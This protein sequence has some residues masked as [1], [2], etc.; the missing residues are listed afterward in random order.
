MRQTRTGSRR[1]A[2]K[3]LVA[4]FATAAVLA[5]CGGD[6]G[7]DV[8]TDDG[9]EPAGGSNDEASGSAPAAGDGEPD[10]AAFPVTIEHALGETVIEEL[11]ETI[12]TVGFTD[13]DTVLALGVQPAGVR[14]WYGDDP[15]FPWAQELVDGEQP[16]VIGDGN[17]INLEAVAQLEP[18]LIIGIYEDLADNYETLSEIAPT[19]TQSGDYEQW[20]QPWQ[21]TTRMVGEALG[22]TDEAEELIS[23]VEDTFADARADHPEFEGQTVAV[24][25]FGEGDGTYYLRHS[26]D[27]R[28]QFFT[29]LGF[30]V[31]EEI[32]QAIESQGDDVMSFERLD[33]VDQ[34]VAVWLAGFESE[35]LVAE[36]QDSPVY[37]SL[38]VTQEGRDLFLEEGVDELGWATVLSVP[39]AVDAITPQLAE[40]VQ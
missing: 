20:A 9:S 15:L 40:I 39:A 19:I 14:H 26:E 5:A 13:H 27:L 7:S 36:V 16:E 1:G 17:A 8:S 4:A 30:T 32:D 38:D 34:D 25:Q 31:P 29:D 10:E 21:E 3:G 11:P 2:R 35:D 37:Q 23:G 18:D 22:R 24:T 28:A 12:V 33:L 6:D